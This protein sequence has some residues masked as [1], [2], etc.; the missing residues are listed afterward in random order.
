MAVG[1]IRLKNEPAPMAWIGVAL[2]VILLGML[3]I[4]PLGMTRSRYPRRRYKEALLFQGVM[5][6]AFVDAFLSEPSIVGAAW[7]IT[8]VVA[9]LSL[10]A[11]AS[12]RYATERELRF[13][14]ADTLRA[15][16]Q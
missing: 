15:G 1:G 14:A 8:G 6:F 10:L 2:G 4:L 7:V 16:R 9:I 11:P 3:F 13:V 5:L 12:R